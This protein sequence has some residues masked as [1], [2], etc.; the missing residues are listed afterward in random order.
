MEQYERLFMG[1]RIFTR[2]AGKFE[3]Q[4]SGRVVEYGDALGIEFRGRKAIIEVA[5][6]PSVLDALLNDS[7]LIKI[8][9]L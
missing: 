9:K 3:D 5:A 4:E 6:V 7:E 1:G 2:P 8:L